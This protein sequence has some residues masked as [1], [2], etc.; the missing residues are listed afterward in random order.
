MDTSWFRRGLAIAIFAQ[1]MLPAAEFH[2]REALEKVE[3]RYNGVQTIQIE[4]E[5]TLRYTSQP[6]ASRT[7]SGTLYL[8]RPGKM[9]WD[10]RTPARKLFLSD[11]KDAYFYSPAMNRAEKTKLKESDDLRA[12]LAFLLGRLDF[13]RDFK[14]YRTRE[15]NGHRWITALPKSAKAPYKEVQFQLTPDFRIA[16]LRV[17]GHDESVMDYTFQK[18][19]LNAQVDDAM[20]RFDLPAGAE[21]VDMSKEQQ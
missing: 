17:L 4:F 16:E 2:L 7:E 3:N 13:D 14:E 12:P 11:G 5:Q 15:E 9:R 8:R 18:E 19:R 10:Y 20:F 1:G 21:L 6:K